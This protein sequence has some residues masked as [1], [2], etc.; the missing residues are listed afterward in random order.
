MNVTISDKFASSMKLRSS[1]QNSYFQVIRDNFLR[2]GIPSSSYVLGEADGGGEGRYCLHL[3]GQ[4]WTVYISERGER[5]GG[6][7]F[8][9]RWDAASYL[10]YELFKGLSTG[11]ESSFPLFER[12]DPYAENECV[13]S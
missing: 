11:T 5:L 4:F 1:E 8:I 9:D 2:I 13:R 7:F 10:M 12:P 6:T 3:E